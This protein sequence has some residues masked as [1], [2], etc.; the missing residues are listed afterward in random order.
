MSTTASTHSSLGWA[1][2]LPTDHALSADD[3]AALPADRWHYEIVS[4]QLLRL[5]AADLRYDLI[6][7]DFLRT[8]GNFVRA[9][10]LGRVTLADSGFLVSA[11]GEPDTVMVPAVAFVRAEH[12]PDETEKA[13]YLRVV[14]DL[15]IEIAA[16]GQLRPALAEKAALWLGAGVRLVWVVWPNR[17]QVEVSS[18]VDGVPS[19]R[20]LSADETLD[21]GEVLP[22]FS[23]SVQHIFL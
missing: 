15:V 12:A 14:P 13:A 2:V 23:V 16:P 9:N 7:G 10:A 3:W 21:G 19:T 17:R 18:L 4:G 11:P 8:I 1:E 22:G 6:A 20:T 5:P